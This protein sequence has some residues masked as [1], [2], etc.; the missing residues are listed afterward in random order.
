MKVSDHPGWTEDIDSKTMFP[1]LEKD[2]EVDVAI[3]GGGLTGVTAAYLLAIHGKKVA[4]LEKEKVG[5][6]ATEY[7]TAFI[8]QVI[9]TDLIELIE[10]FGKEKAHLI[11]ESGKKAI[12]FIEN[13]IK[14]EKIECEFTR[15]SSFMYA[16]SQ[17]DMKH[18]KKISELAQT[19]DFEVNFSKDKNLNFKNEGYIENKNQAKFHPLKYLKHLAKVAN[20]KGTLIFE[21]TEALEIEG[22]EPVVVKTQKAKVRAPYVIIATY[23][24][25]GNPI[26]ML[27]RNALYITYIIEAKIPENVLKD[28]IY[29]D[30]ASPY[31]YFRVDKKVGY[32]RLIIGGEDH[33]SELKIDPEKNYKSLENYLKSIIPSINYEIIR[34]WDGPILE[35]ID[36]LPFIGKMIRNDNHLV[37]TG[38]S[39][40]GMTYSAIAAIIL[41][42]IIMGNKNQW[43]ELYDAKRIPTIP[44]L[45]RKGIDYTK[46]LYGGAIKN[47]FQMI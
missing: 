33:R 10:M 41:K 32:D 2:L 19:L 18:L 26:E 3:I 39:G 7:T 24:T 44:Q 13:V 46:V 42:D 22:N 6:G 9:D 12:D 45:V 8:T 17:D 36:G 20:Q 25:M 4:L 15:C 35:T 34:K 1:K 27:L 37:A 47:T 29:W 23:E 28:A 31:H 16:N 40:N 11:W 21:E 14:K 43:M 38:F 30:I 5:D